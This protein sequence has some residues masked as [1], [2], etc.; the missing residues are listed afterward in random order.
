M[1]KSASV[2]NFK[3]NFM[4]CISKIIY[5][6]VSKKSQNDM[7]FSYLWVLVDVRE[8]CSHVLSSQ[9]VGADLTN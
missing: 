7:K 3:M 9:Y 1:G 4:Q 5:V 6:E 8:H 2:T